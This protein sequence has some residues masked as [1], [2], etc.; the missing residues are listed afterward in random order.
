MPGDIER[1]LGLDLPEILAGADDGIW[2]IG[3]GLA[4][5]LEEAQ[6]GVR[7]MGESSR[8]PTFQAWTGYLLAWLD[9]RVPDMLTLYVR[10]EGLKIVDDPEAIFQEGWLLCDAGAH[11]LGLDRLV[12]AVDKG[13]FPARTLAHARAFDALRGEPRFTAL[14]ARAEAGRRRARAAFVAAGGERLLGRARG[15]A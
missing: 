5:R 1:V 7:R 9:R 6:A 4:G 12:R 8:I 11:E 2:V 14:V 15:A 10:L 3:L 13:Y